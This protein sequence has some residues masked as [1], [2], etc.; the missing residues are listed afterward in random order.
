MRST[1]LEGS[2]TQKFGNREIERVIGRTS[3]D[4]GLRV[5]HTCLPWTVY[6]FVAMVHTQENQG[7]HRD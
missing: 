2:S 1:S 4:T 7:S 6:E 5:Y 3:R